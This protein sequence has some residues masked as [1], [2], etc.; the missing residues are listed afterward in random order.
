MN[1]D[2]GASRAGFN[3]SDP[4]R[5]FARTARAVVIDPGKFFTDLRRQ[6]APNNPLLFGVV[7]LCISF[8][9]GEVLT[10]LNPSLPDRLDFVSF[11]GWLP[12][13]GAVA[14]ASALVIVPLLALVGVYVFAAIQDV[15]VA[16]FVRHGEGFDATLC[17]VAY[18]SVLVPLEEIPVVWYLA[19]LYGI[20]ISWV[21]LRELHTTTRVRALFA[22]LAFHAL[23]WAPQIF[24]LFR[25][26]SGRA[27]G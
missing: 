10:L 20:Y 9:F 16:I 26:L 4:L 6:E 3:V 1:S 19:A 13:E 18:S 8:L 25:S 2:S 24:S 17:A 12:G 14:V 7:C 22:V 15:F 23:L 27:F 5:S 21:G 11:L